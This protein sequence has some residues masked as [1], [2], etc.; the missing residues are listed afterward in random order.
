MLLWIGKGARLIR[1]YSR[2]PQPA[3][4]A[5]AVPD[6]HV[7]ALVHVRARVGEAVLDGTHLLC[8]SGG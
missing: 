4:V 8:P 7:P 5:P 1:Q 2:I 6:A 3:Q